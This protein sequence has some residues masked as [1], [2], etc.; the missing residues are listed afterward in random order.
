MF[1]DQFFID[2]ARLLLRGILYTVYNIV[3]GILLKEYLLLT[4]LKLVLK[5]KHRIKAKKE[6]A[7][8]KWRIFFAKTPIKVEPEKFKSFMIYQKGKKCVTS[9]SVKRHFSDRFKHYTKLIAEFWRFSI[10]FPVI[11][12]MTLKEKSS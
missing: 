10:S 6:K 12:F 8:Q 9:P 5:P 1:L 2:F 3:K 11:P 4:Q 7:D